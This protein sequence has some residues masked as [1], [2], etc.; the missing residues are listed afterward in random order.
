V[1]HLAIG[2]RN[3]PQQLNEREHLTKELFERSGPSQKFLLDI[4]GAE[5]KVYGYPPLPKEA[6]LWTAAEAVEIPRKH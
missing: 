5:P 1:L 4:E 6:R 2:R 3:L